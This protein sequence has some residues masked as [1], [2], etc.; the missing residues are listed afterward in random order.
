MMLFC[1]SC[2]IPVN[3]MANYDFHKA[4]GQVVWFNGSLAN[5]KWKE[6]LSGA[7]RTDPATAIIPCNNCYSG[8]F[9]T[10]A[11]TGIPTDMGSCAKF[12]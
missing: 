4:H 2:I 3:E 11:T 10:A 9:L 5:R 7:S 6:Q 8:E 1:T 12:G